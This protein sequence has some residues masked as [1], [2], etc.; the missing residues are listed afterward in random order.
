MLRTVALLGLAAESAAANEFHS[1]EPF[2]FAAHE[3][4]QQSLSATCSGSASPTPGCYEGTAGPFFA[5]ETIK[6]HVDQFA[7][8]AGTMNLMGSG[9]MGFTCAERS[10]T[11][12]GQAVAVD[13]HDCLPAGVS[14]PHV[15]YCSD[16]D[17]VGV[18]VKVDALGMSLPATLK[19]VSCDA[20]NNIDFATCTG[21][22]DFESETC[23][24]G[25]AGKF[26]LTE[27]VT[28]KIKSQDQRKGVMTLSGTGARSFT[29][30]DHAFWKAKYGQEVKVDVSDCTPRE[31]KVSDVKYCSDQESIK[32]TVRD[33]SMPFIAPFSAMLNRVECSESTN[34]ALSTCSGSGDPAPGCYEGTAGPWF[35]KETVAV[36]VEKYANGAGVMN[37]KGSGIMGFSCGS[38][39]FTSSGQS[40]SVDLSD[41]LPSGVSVPNVNYCSDADK[42]EVKVKVDA[43]GMTLPATLKRVSCSAAPVVV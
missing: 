3:A 37:L 33:P 8:G 21:D 35:A 16:S 40:V 43:L 38:R 24:E 25:K 19:K 20:S 15:N 17:T 11:K 23:Y 6:V 18:T 28:V 2:L 34:S 10:F 39:S 26:G 41:C 31:L 1:L 5:K 7:N 30:N 27:D 13:L 36:N 42:V 9:I 22:L 14:V 4:Q 29:C 32:V 12:S